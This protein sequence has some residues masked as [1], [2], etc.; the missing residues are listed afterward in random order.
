[1]LEIIYL[2]AKT[3]LLVLHTK[4]V[5]PLNH[6]KMNELCWNELLVL[7]SNNWTI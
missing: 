7:N 2:C 6:V 3:E 4:Y 1:M 5:E